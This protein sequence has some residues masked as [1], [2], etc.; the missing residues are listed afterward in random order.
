MTQL[1]TSPRPF[2]AGFNNLLSDFFW[3]LARLWSQRS[4][5]KMVS[6]GPSQ[7]SRSGECLRSTIDGTGF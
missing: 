1:K 5:R 4:K 3:Q 7:H 2:D 6:L